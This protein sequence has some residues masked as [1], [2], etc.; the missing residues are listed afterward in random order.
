MALPY[1]LIRNYKDWTASDEHR[2]AVAEHTARV[3]QDGIDAIYFVSPSIDGRPIGKMVHRA[4]FERSALRGIRM[5]PLSFTDFRDNLWGE[6][7]GFGQEDAEGAMVPDLT[8]FRQLPWQ[9]RLARVLC[10]YYD[11]ESGEL[12]D[13]DSR[14]TLARHQHAFHDETG[15]DMFVGIEP[16][17]MWLKK[18]DDGALD[19]TTDALAFYEIAYLEELE[20]ITLDLLKYGTDMQL[21]FSHADSE[22]RSQ[23]EMNQRPGPPLDYVD[24]FFTYRQLCRIVARKHGLIATFMPKPFMGCSANGHHHNVS[25][26]NEAGENELI[27]TEKGDCRLSELGVHFLGGLIGHA[28][29]LTLVGS[30]TANSYSRF[31]DVGYWAPFHKSYGF[32]NRSCLFRIADVGR[33]EARQMDASCNPYLSVGSCLVAGLDGIRQRTDPGE[34]VQDNMMLDIR[35]PREQRIPI[36]LTEAIDAFKADDLMRDLLA[37]RMYATFVGLRE[38]DFQRSCAQVSAWERE[39]Y[40]ERWP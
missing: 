3:E 32:N 26:M 16:E 24:D 7:I 10:F 6:P 21:R 38:D 4:Q 9:P 18:R 8:T 31:W 5:H 29:A 23:V 36:T 30:P 15:V 27:G 1:R 22:D 35:V 40:L 33:I 25:L 19:H 37:P 2:Q 34:P 17:L 20:P 13:A 12:L 14:G 39:F 11:V 28:D